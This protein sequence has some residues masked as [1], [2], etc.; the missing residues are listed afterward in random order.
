VTDSELQ[1]DYQQAIAL[2]TAASRAQCPPAAAI[3]ALAAGEGKERDRLTTLDHVMACAHCQ[4]EFEL[5]RAIHT[6]G[7]PRQAAIQPRWYALAAAL[8]V[9][10]AL[11]LFTV[12]RDA[13]V[14]RGSAGADSIPVPI[15]PIGDVATASVRL[16]VWGSFAGAAQYRI[17]VLDPGGALRAAASVVDTTWALTDSV[18]LLP[19]DELQWT[20]EAVMPDARRVQSR[21]VAFRVR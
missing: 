19:G 16:F 15:A 3:E 12:R 9:V 10:V 7:A 1:R 18:A 13:S 6:A 20:V 2:R 4:R 8:L 11:S 21:I 5:L 14:L 17:E